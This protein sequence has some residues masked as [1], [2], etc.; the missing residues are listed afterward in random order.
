MNEL[1]SEQEKIMLKSKILLRSIQNAQS[2]IYLYIYKAKIK[3]RFD[4]GAD[5]IL[6]KYRSRLNY[7]GLKDYKKLQFVDYLCREK[8]HDL[9]K[10]ARNSEKNI[11]DSEK[12]LDKSIEVLD[13]I[14]RKHQNLN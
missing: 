2:Q 10:Y 5:R 12:V 6:D 4:T 8:I 7:K 11:E 3:K 9:Q 1:L 13:D 14:L